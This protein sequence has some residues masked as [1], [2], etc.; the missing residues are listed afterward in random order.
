MLDKPFFR[1][2]FR[3]RRALILADGF[4]EWQKSGSAKQAY[5]FEVREG[6]LFAF[7]GVWDRW[8]G[9]SGKALET[10]SILTTT[11]NAVT[12]AVHDRMPVIIPRDSYG[13]WLDPMNEDT[14]QLKGLLASY[15]AARME[16]YP[17]SK[18]VSN[19]RNEGAELI[20]GT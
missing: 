19:A 14:K 6:E 20:Q 11:P 3:W 8:K 5:C 15:P 9:P 1:E 7:A 16:A 17:V 13:T 12:A 10:F 2:A 18:A 4:Y